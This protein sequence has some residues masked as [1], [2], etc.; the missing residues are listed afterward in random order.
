MNVSKDT[1]DI[2]FFERKVAQNVRRLYE[3][4]LAKEEQSLLLER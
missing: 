2:L 1:K 4:S 3:A